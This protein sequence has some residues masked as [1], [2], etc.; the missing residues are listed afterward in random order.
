MKKSNKSTSKV[1]ETTKDRLA[2]KFTEEYQEG[3]NDITPIRDTWDE[4]EAMMMGHTIDTITKNEAKSKVFDPRLSTIAFERMMRVTAQMPSGKIQALTKE[5]K[6]KSVF[7]NLI[8]QNYV[9]PNANT[10][11]DILTKYRLLDFYSMVYGSMFALVDYVVKDD[12]IGPDFHILPIRNVI[13]QK[14][15]YN[16]NDSD[17]IFVKY[18][19]SDAWLLKQSTKIWKNIDKLIDA[20]GQTTDD[21]ETHNERKYT[22]GSSSKLHDIYTCYER[23]RWVTFS[24]DQKLILRDIKNPHKNGELPVVGKHAFPL[25]DRFFGLGDFEKG[26]TLQLATNSL[27]NLYLDGV[28]MSIY[29]PYKVYLP[30]IVAQTLDQRPGAMWVLKN[31]NPNAISQVSISPQGINSFQS[32]YQFLIAATM[33][34]AGT[35]DT[36]VSREADISQGKTPQALKQMAM[37]EGARDNFDRFMLEKTMEQVTDRFVDL[38][39]KKQE[40]PIKLQ[41]LAK[42][43]E[44][45]SKIYPDA[46]QMFE[47]NNMGEV[48]VDPKE[49]KDIDYKFTIDPGSTMKKDEAIENETLTNLISLILKIPGA[50]EEA[51]Q[52]GKVTFGDKVFEF[53]ESL[54]RYVMSSGIQD[55]DKLITDLK[56]TQDGSINGL[57]SDPQLQAMMGMQGGQQQPSPQPQMP[58]AM[59]MP[60]PMP[61]QG[62]PSQMPQQPIQQPQADISGLSPESLQVLQD[63]HDYV[64]AGNQ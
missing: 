26:R 20:E 31:N 32:T 52:T 10:Q 17:K 13:P 46:V 50:M 59:P 53:A 15:K 4:K 3:Y 28:K 16:L 45:V 37:R 61:Q 8:Y 48:I 55:S 30:D 49:V 41:L 42:E 11:Y 35:T 54:K 21:D 9:L 22:S 2:G 25:L 60:Q 34:Q 7:M 5:D 64:R 38:I 27:I 56:N 18:R 51:K 43:L 14:G 57:E 62:M 63:L 39:A 40:K 1:K 47:S 58:G 29:P 36:S 44:E 19:V 24:K 23:D 12:Y 6:G 33:N